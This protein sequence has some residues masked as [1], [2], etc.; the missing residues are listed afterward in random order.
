MEA[1]ARDEP[2]RIFPDR[3]SCMK[4]MTLAEWSP[5]ETAPEGLPILVTDGEFIVVAQLDSTG[6]PDAVGFRG[7]QWDWDFEETALTHWLPLPELPK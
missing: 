1:P 6:W 2:F 7:N 4:G 5:I 3:L